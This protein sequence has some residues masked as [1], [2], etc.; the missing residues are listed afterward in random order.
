MPKDYNKMK[1]LDLVMLATTKC[2]KKESMDPKKVMLSNSVAWPID[3][4]VYAFSLKPKILQA[5]QNQR[6]L[7]KYL[8]SSTSPTI[9]I[10]AK[11]Q[12]MMHPPLPTPS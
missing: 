9:F 10:R 2:D 1:S 3:S 6:H 12:P 4:Q 11:L 8:T 7:K 5:S